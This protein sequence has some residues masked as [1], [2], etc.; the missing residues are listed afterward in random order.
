MG[1]QQARQVETE[2]TPVNYTP[3]ATPGVEGDLEGIDAALAGASIASISG[4]VVSNAA[5]ADH[6]IDTGTGVAVSSES[7]IL[8]LAVALIKQIDAAWAVGTNLGGL[9]TGAVAADTTY[10][11]FLIEKDS[12]LSLDAGFDTDIGAANIPAGYT[13]FKRLTSV[14]T[15]GSSN[16]IPFVADEISGGGLEVKWTDPPLDLSAVTVTVA[17]LV[18]LQVPID[19]KVEAHMNV[20]SER[21]GGGSPTITYLSSPDQNDEVPS[22]TVAPLATIITHGDSIAVEVEKRTNT[23]GQIRRRSDDTGGTLSIS[24]L[25]YID[26]RI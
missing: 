14:L 25:H 17:A 18:T 1:N 23:S 5:D 10:H 21:S 8:T 24:T 20:V 6:D 7:D 12:D 22:T 16:I 3:G 13:A 9:F 26:E 11:F 2:L 19:I 15:D 4:L